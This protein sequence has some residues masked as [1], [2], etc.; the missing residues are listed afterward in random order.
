M[1]AFPLFLAVAACQSSSPAAGPASASACSL[2]VRFGSYAMGIDAGAAAAIDTLLAGSADV[3]GVRRD[4][5]GREGE[6]TL[7]VTA[8]DRAA[9]AQLFEAV[10][11]LLP[12]KPRG[13]ISVEGAGRRA[14]AP[15]R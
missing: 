2:S 6:Y 8:R 10:A 5:W 3:K 1:K 12:D 11:A 9:S 13:P 4:G 15:A 7:C 14:D